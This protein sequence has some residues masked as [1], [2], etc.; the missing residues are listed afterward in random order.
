MSALRLPA[1]VAL[2]FLSFAAAAHELRPAFL[3]LVEG[4]PETY[5]VTW[6]VPALG[7]LRLSLSVVLPANCRET[8][9]PVA[10]HAEGADVRRWQVACE[11]GL[12]GRQ[13]E[14]DGLRAT[15]TDALVRL[16]LRDG[17]V[18][19]VRLT[20]DA[21]AVTVEEAPTAADTARTYFLL[22]TH[23]ILLG[24]D[25][26]L[27]V[28]ALLMLIG[29]W[30]M[31]LWTITAFTLAH[32]ITLAAAALGFARAPQPPVE[33]MVALSIAFVAAEIVRTARGD[34]AAESRAPWAIAFVFGLLHGF[35]FGGALAE[36][37]L[38]QKD[39]PLALLTF[40]LGVEAGQLLVVALAM[41]AAASL[42][43]LL[44][45]DFAAA[46]LWLGYGAGSLA[47]AWFV[48]RVAGIVA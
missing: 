41:A 27:F 29:S 25:H 5:D 15:F 38:P 7:G 8:R 22:G 24:L 3:E 32:S 33:A 46:R 6:K 17:T 44:A 28:L 16:Q 36:I 21:P 35:G 4:G 48:Q 30:R 19:T 20:P 39:V 42:R 13:I 23:H 26:L 37:G 11:G 34:A 14:I 2:V 45:F 40:H 1:T 43:L 18:Q 10:V 31:L 47:A 12:G 9:P